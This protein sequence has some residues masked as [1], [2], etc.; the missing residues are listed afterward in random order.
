ML[1]HIR[2]WKRAVTQKARVARYGVLNSDTNTISVGS[3]KAPKLK[4]IIKKLGCCGLL[5]G[6]RPKAK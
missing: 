3:A 4:T 2:N 6:C 1:H 5:S